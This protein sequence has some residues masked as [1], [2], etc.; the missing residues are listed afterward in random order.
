MGNEGA[1]PHREDGSAN[2]DEI[3][4][5]YSMSRFTDTIE[6]CNDRLRANAEDRVGSNYKSLSYYGLKQYENALNCIESN[7]RKDSSFAD[8][9]YTKFL[10]LL[11]ME[12]TDE[13]KSCARKAVELDQTFYTCM[14]FAGAHNSINDEKY[15]DALT[16]L[17]LLIELGFDTG[18]IWSQK[19]RILA[20]NHKFEEALTC[21]DKEIMLRDGIGFLQI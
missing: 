9:Y 6:L 14:I 21:Y 11:R 12:R 15:D 7:F 2:D 10:I 5:L 4:R 1:N 17:N 13:A 18:E 16:F 8:G 3:R 19:A 20:L